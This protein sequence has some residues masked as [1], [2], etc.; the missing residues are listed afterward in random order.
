MLEGEGRG[1]MLAR[2][3]W[4]SLGVDISATRLV[5]RPPTKIPSSRALLE[6]SFERQKTRQGQ[7][8]YQRER[9]EIRNQELEMKA[10]STTMERED[11]KRRKQERRE[12]ERL[13]E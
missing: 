10:C 8:D 7:K 12:R 5:E 4:R 2:R 6:L 13:E 11:G 3:A 1:L 9:R